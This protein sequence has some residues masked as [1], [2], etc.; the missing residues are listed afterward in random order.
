MAP[1]SSPAASV[2]TTTVYVLRISTIR[3]N[4]AGVDFGPAAA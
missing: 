4:P 1:E 2:R 3:K